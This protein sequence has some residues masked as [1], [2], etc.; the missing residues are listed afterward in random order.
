MEEVWKDIPGY[1]GLYQ[2]STWGNVRTKDDFKLLKLHDLRGYKSITLSKDKTQK[3]FRVHRLVAIAFIPNLNSYPV[4]NHKDENPSNNHVENLEWCTYSYNNN[5]GTRNAR[6][7]KKMKENWRDK[8]C[9]DK[10]DLRKTRYKSK[11]VAQYDMQGNLIDIYDSIAEAETVTGT[12]HS[13]ISRAT[14]GL[15]NY[16]YGY[17]WVLVPKDKVNNA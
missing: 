17:K 13:S 9:G 1:E 3:S 8:G 11:K 15:Q 12:C 16:A 2:V 6:A 10:P 5:Y 4:I 14:R 7:S